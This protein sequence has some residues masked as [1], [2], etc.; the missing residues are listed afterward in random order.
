[1]AL[2]WSDVDWL[3]GKLHVQRGIVRQ[4][5]DDLKTTESRKQMSVDRELLKGLKAWKHVIQFP[6]QDDWV[7]ASPVQPW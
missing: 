3:K 7:F 4:R 5:V 1:L 2:K 6:A